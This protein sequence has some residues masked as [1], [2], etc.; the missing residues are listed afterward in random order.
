MDFITWYELGPNPTMPPG[1]CPSFFPLPALYPNTSAAANDVLP[2]FVIKS[3]HG[4]QDWMGTS[5]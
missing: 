5:N 2:N 1:E 3:S 4:G